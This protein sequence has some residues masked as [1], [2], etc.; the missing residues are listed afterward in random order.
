M[1]GLTDAERQSYMTLWAIEAA[2]LYSG[3]DLTKLDSYGLS[4]LTNDEVIAVDQAGNPAK[5]VSQQHRPAGLVRPE[6]RRQLHRR[7]VQPRRHAG[8][9]HRELERPGHRR[10]PRP[11]A[12]CGATPDL[13]HA[14]GSF[15]ASLPAHGSRLLRITPRDIPANNPSTPANLHGTASTTSSVS[16]A[17]D[18][19]GD[20]GAGAAGYHVYVGS[21]LAGSVRQPSVTVT[22]LA[23]AT[24]YAFTVAADG[25]GRQGIGAQSDARADHARRRRPDIVRG[26]IVC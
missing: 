19:S 4:L 2:P 17:W 14:T 25:P 7:A 6:Q 21:A 9:R 20:R 3:D 10:D 15:T 12:T 16:L 5:P 22:G 26:G 24:T 1:D 11:C 23:P 18:P 13:G 8:D